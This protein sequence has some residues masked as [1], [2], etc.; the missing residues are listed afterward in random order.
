MDFYLF[1][2]FVG[3]KYPY[4]LGYLRCLLS[5][6]LLIHDPVLIYDKCHDP[7]VTILGRIC[8]QGKSTNHAILHNIIICT[9]GGI[10][11]L[12]F[13]Y[14]EIVAMVGTGFA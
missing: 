3:I 2:G 4:C 10:L 6:I 7:G 11:S 14:S 8:H 13:Q 12:G 5:E 1:P 9:T